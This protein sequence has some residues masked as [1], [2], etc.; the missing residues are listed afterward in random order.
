MAFLSVGVL[1]LALILLTGLFIAFLVYAIAEIVAIVIEGDPE[2]GRI[3]VSF[4]SNLTQ[5]VSTL[6]FGVP[7]ARNGCCQ[8]H[9]H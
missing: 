3:E 4:P 7:L 8:R 5:Q 6:T 9:G 2:M 1:Q